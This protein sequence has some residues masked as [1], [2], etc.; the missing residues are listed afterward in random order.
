MGMRAGKRTNKC[1]ATDRK[2]WEVCEVRSLLWRTGSRSLDFQI[3]I[4]SSTGLSGVKPASGQIS[5][6][7]QAADARRQLTERCQ[8]FTSLARW[9]QQS[10]SSNM[11]I[12]IN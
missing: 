2:T 8:V 3:A 7:I 5:G 6:Q 12:A 1:C 4:R 9:K 10:F 11:R